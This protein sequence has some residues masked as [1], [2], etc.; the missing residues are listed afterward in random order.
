MIS[1]ALAMPL[2]E[3]IQF[4][5]SDYRS[6]S[7]EE[8]KNLLGENADLLKFFACNDRDELDPFHGPVRFNPARDSLRVDTGSE[9]LTYKEGRFYGQNG[10]LVKRRADEFFQAVKKAF[11][12]FENIEP[13]RK[14][15]R[16]LEASYFPLT[17]APGRNSFSPTIP[18]LRTWSGLFQAQSLMFLSTLR[19]AP[20]RPDFPFGDI[21]A[22]GR[23]LWQWNLHALTI[24]SDGVKRELDPHVALAHEMYHAFDSIRGMLDLRFVKGED[25]AFDQV[26]EYRAVYF[27]NMV[28]KEL[29]IKYRKFYGDPTSLEE[30]DV[31]DEQGEPIY[32]S[33]PCLK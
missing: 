32:I 24:E 21:G 9:L 22:G 23:I 8:L 19:M 25:Y 28:R 12:R 30:P 27:E 26:N 7:Q 17:V 20:V 4:E 5:S 1:S 6:W 16:L 18:G 31:L 14:L 2:Y 15:L 29:G 11:L 33:S 3:R 13:T 10:K